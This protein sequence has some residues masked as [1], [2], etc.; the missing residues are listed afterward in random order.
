M[1]IFVIL[2]FPVQAC[3]LQ[4]DNVSKLN[5]LS[6][7]KAVFVFLPQYFCRCYSCYG[8]RLRRLLHLSTKLLLCRLHG[9]FDFANRKILSSQLQFIIIIIILFAQLYSSMH[10]CTNTILEEWT[11][12]SDMNTNSCPKTFNKNSHWV[13]ILS[14][15]YKYYKREKL[16]RSIFSILFV[17]HLK[18]QVAEFQ[19]HIWK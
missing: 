10:I 4:S 15:K 11:A 9:L 18:M 5:K 6:H 2:S 1:I 13:H 7:R 17:K 12:R 8:F 14:H 19:L 16:E 3:C